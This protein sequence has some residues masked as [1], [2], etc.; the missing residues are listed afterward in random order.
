[1]KISEAIEKRWSPRAFDQ[2]EVD[3]DLLK[4]LLKA[5]GTAPSCFNEQ[6]WRYMVGFK[7]D[8]SYGKI[9]STLVEFNQSWC[10][11]AP[12]LMLGIVN[13]QFA[14]NGKANAHARHDLGQS[15]SYLTLQAMKHDVYV[16]QM[17]GFDEEKA[18]EVFN[19]PEDHEAVTAL[20]LGYLGDKD[21]LNDDLKDQESPESPRKSLEEIAFEGDWNQSIK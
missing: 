5:A 4:S 6:P 18:R 13:K 10:K 21:Q 19:I 8:E 11:T 9:T 7:G 12:V 1:M 17:A 14:K 2:K 16:H 20:A 3:R 15:S